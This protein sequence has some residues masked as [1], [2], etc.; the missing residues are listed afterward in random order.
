MYSCFQEAIGVKRNF[1]VPIVF[2][3]MLT[4]GL[5][6]IFVMPKSRVSEAENR[7]LAKLP[8]LNAETVFSGRFAK[9]MND[10]LN[11]HFPFRDKLIAAGD[12]ISSA[13]SYKDE[14]SIQVVDS[15][16]SDDMDEG[17]NLNSMDEA[18]TEP[19]K[20]EE[21]PLPEAAHIEVAEEADYNRGGIIISGTRAMELFG[22]NYNMLTNYASAVNVIK[23]AVPDGVNVYSLVAPTSVEF[24]S[25]VKYHT[26]MHSQKEALEALKSML[27]DG[28]TAVDAYPYLAA[29]ADEYIYFRTDHHWTAR[30]AYQAYYA[31]CK[32]AKIEPVPIDDFT[33]D[34]C[35]YDFV[36]SLYRYTKSQVIKDNPDYV[37]V[38][39]QPQVESS[40]AFIGAD[41]TGEYGAE[42]I[43]DVSKTGN[44]YLVF[45]GGD[46]PLMRIVS[47]VKNGRRLLVFKDSFGNALVPFMVN[48]YEEIYVV[49]PRSASLSVADFCVEH[50]I[51]DVIIEN[52]AFVISNSAILDGLKNA[53]R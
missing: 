31:F 49:D 48:H 53:A 16:I 23:T 28:I 12:G 27:M 35:S 37:E 44:K 22:Y 14:D 51:N 1:I 33:S 41:M 43:S 2:L 15:P 5:L 10:Y 8:K 50:S 21:E 24:Y 30:G 7:R 32:A 26:G 11:D 34:I 29:A 47:K 4:V 19:E 45:L 18:E 3:S 46:H 52:Y 39:Y 36:G 25:P 9:G 38:F 42:V 6:L 17:E 13:L 40:S 20:A